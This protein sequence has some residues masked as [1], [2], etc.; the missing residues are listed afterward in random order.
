MTEVIKLVLKVESLKSLST[1]QGKC[2]RSSYIAKN[3]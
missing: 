1:A 3:G 2:D